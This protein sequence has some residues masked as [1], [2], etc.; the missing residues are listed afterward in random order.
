LQLFRWNAH[1]SAALAAQRA[2][3][4]PTLRKQAKLAHMR[5]LYARVV[6]AVC[7]WQLLACAAE[8][9]DGPQLPKVGGPTGDYP[10]RGGSL[11]GHVTD[12][13]DAGAVAP[14]SGTIGGPGGAVG[15]GIT[16]GTAVAGGAGGTVGAGASPGGGS[17]TGGGATVGGG[18]AGGGA[19]GGVTGGG[20]ESDAGLPADAGTD[21]GDAASSIAPETD[22][23]A[24]Y[25]DGGLAADAPH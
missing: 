23:G 6:L 19:M 1:E 25:V 4:C 15:G 5:P 2:F 9:D 16:G 11:G 22:C 14:P 24:A 7:L 21:A 18:V 20:A 17:A 13:L 10:D 8:P 3:V 12:A